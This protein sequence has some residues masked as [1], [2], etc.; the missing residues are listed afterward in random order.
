VKRACRAAAG[1]DD[2]KEQ[3]MEGGV[4]A[5]GPIAVVSKLKRI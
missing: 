5:I 1:V 2:I 3:L 4:Q